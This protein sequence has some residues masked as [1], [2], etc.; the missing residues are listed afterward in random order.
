MKAET[1]KN[2]FIC[3]ITILSVFFVISCFAYTE[4]LIEMYEHNGNQLDES[5]RKQQ[6]QPNRNF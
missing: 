5:K 1:A 6:V 3:V 4:S 2:A